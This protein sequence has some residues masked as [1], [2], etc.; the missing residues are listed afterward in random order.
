VTIF[1]YYIGFDIGGLRVKAALVENKNI[2]NSTVEDLPGSFEVLV[3]VLDKMFK[4]LTSGIEADKISGLGFSFAGALDA[5]REKMLNSPN[6]QFLNGQPLKKTLEEKFKPY[7]VKIEHDVH[8]YLIAEKEAGL[9]KGLKNVFYLTLGTGIGGAFL[10]D[11][12]IIFGSHGAAG[13]AGHM[14][15]DICQ[16]LDFE[17]MASTKAIRRLLGVDSFKA[18]DLVRSGDKR[19]QEAFR[20]I[21]EDLGIGLANII[22]IFDPEAIIIGGGASWMKE[23]VLPGA[24]KKIEKLVISPAARKTEI[25][26]SE[27]SR[28]GGALGAALLFET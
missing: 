3:L 16:E 6:I 28:F 9:A 21:S 8:C 20:R 27:M 15:L 1:M 7:L 11:G 2:V 12:K 19:A 17:D 5:K 23:F 10:V 24:K 18:E 26:F 14:I 4:D 13:E 22:N 25:L